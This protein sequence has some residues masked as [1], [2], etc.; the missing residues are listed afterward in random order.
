MCIRLVVFTAAE[1]CYICNV[2]AV[3]HLNVKC[4]SILRK[5]LKILLGEANFCPTFETT[6]KVFSLT[7]LPIIIAKIL[8]NYIKFTIVYKVVETFFKNFI[9]KSA[10]LKCCVACATIKV[11]YITHNIVLQSG[12]SLTWLCIKK[13]FCYKKQRFL[14]CART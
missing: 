4:V 8:M 12:E 10:I 14:E 2:G 1:F 3:I 9:Q 13:Y 7:R 6:L 5:Y 11:N